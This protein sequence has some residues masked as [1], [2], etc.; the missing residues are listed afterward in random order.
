VAGASERPFDFG[1]W[2]VDPSRGVLTAVV[3]REVRLEPQLIDL[4]VLF[5]GSPGRVLAKD[6]II[7]AV[8]GGRAIGDGTLAAAVS[9][10]RRALGETRARRYIETVPKRGYRCLLASELPAGR[11][12]ARA[13]QSDSE[14]AALAARG[15]QALATPLAPNLAQ[16]R[17]YFDAAV[18]ADPAWGPGHRGLA[19]CLI[20]QHMAGLGRGLLAA[21]K[22]AASGAVG[23]D[24]GSAQAWATF[25]L[26]ILFA[27]REFAAADE[28]LRR[29]IALDPDLAVAR[30]NRSTAFR[31]IGRFVEAERDGRKAVE[32]DPH[33][34]EMHVALLHTLI[35]ARRFGQA[36]AEASAALALSPQSS[37]AWY[38]RGWALAMGGDP[39]HGMDA[40]LQGLSLWGADAERIATLRRLFA[41]EGLDAVCRAGAD[42]FEAQALMLPRRPMDV[43]MLRALGGQI[44]LAFAA[45]DEA[46]ERDD[47]V[48]LFV[49]WLPHFDALRGDER[50]ARLMQRLRLVR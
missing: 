11:P 37:D 46:A 49:P 13:H 8:W 3:G 27:D 18:K 4:L 14:A 9:R 10:L 39:A 31:T 25:G 30:R 48:L 38:Q 50:Y 32:L 12:R 6:E 1:D 34:L 19:E 21:A 35:A 36:A 29:A 15:W 5:A 17:S 7:E 23:L 45:L 40:L 28:A 41:S 43:A 44:D 24:P 16:A 26:A 42:L 20:A 22:A 2:R 33:S 47:L